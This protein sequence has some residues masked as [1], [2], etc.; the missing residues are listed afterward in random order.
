MTVHYMVVTF[1]FEIMF[2]PGPA[3][4]LLSTWFN[5]FFSIRLGDSGGPARVPAVFKLLWL[6]H[7]GCRLGCHGKTV[8]PY[9]HNPKETLRPGPTQ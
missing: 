8:E 9:F 2:G 1:L 5:D 7:S 4:A 3:P 6:R